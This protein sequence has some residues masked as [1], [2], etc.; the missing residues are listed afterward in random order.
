MSE[1]FLLG[2]DVGTSGCK[3]SLFDTE[4]RDIFHTVQG[5]ETLY[6]ADG[7]AEQN[8]EHWWIAA[9]R[10]I[11][12]MLAATGMRSDLIKGI[13]VAGQ[14]WAALPVNRQGKALRNAIIWLDRRSVKQCKS[15]V[16]TIG[17]DVLLEAAG[18]PLTPAYTTG[19]IL[20][21]KESEPDL[22]RQTHQ[23]VQSNSYLVYK[24]TGTFSQDVSQGYGVHSFDIRQGRWND[25]MTERM[26][27]DQEKL[28]PI[29]ACD[30]VVG[31]VTIQASGECGLA[32]GIPV[33]AGGLD[34]ACGT[35]GAGVIRSGETQEQGG[36]AGG[37]SIVLD[38]VQMSKQLILGCHVVKSKWLLQGGTVGGGSLRWFA[39]E[40]GRTYADVNDKAEGSLFKLMSE[41]AK[42]IK[43]GSAGLIFLPYMAG[44][45]TPIWDPH[46]KGV[47]VGLSYDKSR[48]HMVK[49]IM[50]GCAYALHHNILTAEALG[51][52]VRQ[53]HGIGGAT[54][55]VMWTQIKA[56]VTG[57][58]FKVAHSDNATTL[59]AALLAGVG[60][61]IYGSYDEAVNRTIK[62]TRTQLPDSQIHKEYTHFFDIYIEAYLRLK[63]LF[64][65]L[66]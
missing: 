58:E 57:K 38:R 32:P 53:L 39:R 49:A 60:A 28:P 2:I 36:Q 30:E 25:A 3:I 24:L 65:K 8:A 26:G 14:S 16:D 35:L 31:Q 7:C 10:G 17:E 42:N 52:Q 27:L 63:D 15:V 40:F 61:G 47:F 51:V 23:F 1:Q 34:A 18:N 12:Q 4:G 46:A 20:W 62:L 59:G 48:A 66:G 64:P 44:E 55:S 9:C 41:E 54:N 21:I 37:M 19:K 43:A 5:Y 50:E 6:P 29:Y 45:R 33:V 56:D 22:Y 11:R 13:G